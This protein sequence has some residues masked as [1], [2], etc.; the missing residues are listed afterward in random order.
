MEHYDDNMLMKDALLQFFQKF[1]IPQ[2]AYSATSFVIR[3]GKWPVHVPNTKSRVY[4][5]KYH[6]LH[7]IVTGYPANWKGEAEIGAWELVTGCRTSFIA[8]FLNSGAVL[9]GLFLYP[10]AVV[11]A[12]QR[13]KS[14]T[15]NLYHDF[16]YAQLLEMTVQQVKVLIG[17]A[18]HKY[19][20]NGV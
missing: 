2:D 14:T 4:I 16:D 11:R 20:G 1:G 10:K 12:F 7:H 19:Q 9:V 17:L 18:G 13:G 3:V 8:W 5:A 6:D 15:T